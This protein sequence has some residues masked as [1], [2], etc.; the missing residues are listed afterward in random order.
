MKSGD[1]VADLNTANLKQW[2]AE[3]IGT[4]K[5]KELIISAFTDTNDKNITRRVS[6]IT[7]AGS[8]FDFSCY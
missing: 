4:K 1:K 6:S 2:S 3:L 8:L 7:S 5:G